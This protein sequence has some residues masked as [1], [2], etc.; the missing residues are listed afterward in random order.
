M[1]R[2]AEPLTP[3]ELD[4]EWPFVEIGGGEPPAAVAET[5]AGYVLEVPM[6]DVPIDDVEVELS[7]PVLIVRRHGDAP[8]ERR[9]VLL[10]HVDPATL[11][12]SLADGRLTIKAHRPWAR[13]RR[14]PVHS[15]FLW[16]GRIGHRPEEPL[17]PRPRPP[18]TR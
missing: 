12:A 13:S 4:T 16:E 7:V 1:T 14:L 11:R 17:P 6:P 5:A 15:D 2:P 9:F 3:Q 18:V 10:A 8:V